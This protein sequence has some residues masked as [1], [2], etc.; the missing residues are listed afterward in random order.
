[1][2]LTQAA[3]IT[4]RGIITIIVLVV[5]AVAG[6]IGYNIWYQNYLASLPPV[7]EKPEMKFGP[8]PKLV[9]PTSSVS[10]SNY[11]YSLDTVTGGLP[12]TPKLLKV[13]F[14]PQYGVTLLAPERSKQLAES[15]GFGLGPEVLSSTK[16]KFNDS[17]GGQLLIDL[18][19]GNFSFQRKNNALSILQAEKLL[20]KEKI[21]VDFKNL[22][23]SRNL[24]NEELSDGKNNV[25]FDVDAKIAIVSLWPKDFD[26]LPIITADFN[27]GLVKATVTGLEEEQDKYPE[28]SY[29]FWTIDNTTFSTY[30]LKT[31]EKAFADLKSGQGHISLEPK[32]PQVSI[33]SVYLAYF[34]SEE[35]SPYLQPVFVFEGPD[36]AAIIPGVDQ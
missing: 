22:L 18:V 36:F 5:L 27:Q 15:F 23:L 14:I 26:N 35:Y 29:T 13:Y 11:S 6:S 28:A 21:V 16:Y 30:P 2:T 31:T 20:E 33:S 3:T 9:F 10:S 34:Q 8:L 1:M 12:Q 25:I 4:R 19:T 7:E 32:N 24:L 17:Q